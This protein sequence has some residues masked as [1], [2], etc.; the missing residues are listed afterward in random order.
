MPVPPRG[1]AHSDSM[2]ASGSSHRMYRHNRTRSEFDRALRNRHTL[3]GVEE[4][5]QH[6]ECMNRVPTVGR[7][8]ESLAPRAAA[9]VAATAGPWRPARRA[10]SGDISVS[11]TGPHDPRPA[12]IHTAAALVANKRRQFGSCVEIVIA[13]PSPVPGHDRPRGDSGILRRRSGPLVVFAT[14]QSSPEIAKA[15]KLGRVPAFDLAIA[16][17]SLACGH[18]VDDFWQ[19]SRVGD[20]CWQ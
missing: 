4:V 11:A 5:G 10:T 18:P 14:Y 17:G 13:G 2:W 1:A 7:P 16:D 3:V 6:P 15:F 9:T 12:A 19:R 8:G 20:R